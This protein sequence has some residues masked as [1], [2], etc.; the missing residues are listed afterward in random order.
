MRDQLIVAVVWLALTAIGEALVGQW[1]R[2]APV[3][4]SAEGRVVDEGIA[5]LLRLAV[6]VFAF[7]VAF[8]LV[9]AV[10]FRA[11]GDGPGGGVRE[12]RAFSWAWLG[13]TGALAV[14]VVVNPGVTG[15]R[16][17]LG[18][19]SPDL[20]V[21]VHARQWSWLFTYPAEG[22]TVKDE[23]VLPVGRRVRFEITAEDVVHAFWVPAFRLKIDAVPG[24]VTV[25]S[26]TPDRE[27]STRDDP[28]VRVQ[29]AELCGT[30]HATMRGAVRVV[31]PGAFDRWAAG[32]RGPS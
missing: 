1:P 15:L 7:V 26:L 25:L 30:G 12:S 28:T 17:I 10:R 14:L 27:I 22:V 32:R 29:C 21:R 2:L 4:A 6:P 23:L 5:L 3:V 13:V 8:L 18:G 16:A 9:A 19:P 20:V 11:R 24:R 31:D